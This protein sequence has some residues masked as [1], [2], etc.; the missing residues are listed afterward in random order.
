MAF[1]NVKS[2]DLPL[3]GKFI[4]EKINNYFEPTRRGT[5]RGESIGFSAKKHLSTLLSLKLSPLKKMAQAVGVS[6]SLLGKWRTE[7][8][9]K[10]L[11]EKHCVEFA[12]VVVCHLTERA[13]IQ[14]KL[15][16]EYFAKP[17]EEISKTPPPRLGMS[18]FSDVKFYTSRLFIHM[19]KRIIEYIKNLESDIENVTLRE[20]AHVQCLMLFEL[21][22]P[23]ILIKR[24]RGDKRI[25]LERLKEKVEKKS[26]LEKM[27]KGISLEAVNEKVFKLIRTM[28]CETELSEHDR[29]F[30]IFM[31]YKIQGKYTLFEI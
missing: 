27:K 9:F 30:I 4:A 23:S 25:A 31:M 8:D 17:L 13:K 12:E 28:L 7:E 15:D 21:L 14:L 1:L 26:A 11:I 10:D 20:A 29:K 2:K 5:P 3:L 24:A 19:A 16:E 18:E 6:P 22:E